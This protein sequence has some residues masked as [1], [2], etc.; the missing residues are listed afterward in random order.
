[1]KRLQK[2]LRYTQWRR[3][4]NTIDK[5]K[6]ACEKSGYNIEEQLP[7]VGKVLEV[8]NNAKMNAKDYRLSRYACYLIAQNGDPRKEVIV[9]AQTYFAI[10]TRKQ[11]LSEKEYSELTGYT[12]KI[13]KIKEEINE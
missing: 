1:M 5:V 4:E 2:I 13:E 8:G 9:L 10:Q 11:E 7:E 6:I 12:I 3:F